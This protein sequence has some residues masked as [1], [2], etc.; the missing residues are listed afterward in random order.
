MNPKYYPIHERTPDY[1]YNDI[2]REIRNSDETFLM[3]HPHQT[4]GRYVNLDT[5]NLI[6]YFRNGFP[7]CTQRQIPFWKK[8]II[9]LLLFMKGVH[10]LEEMT[11]AGC[12][13]WADWVPQEKC[14]EFGLPAGDLGPRASYGPVLTAFP[15]WEINKDTGV[16]E[17][18]PF[19]QIENLISS[20]KDGPHM[21]GH[22]ITTWFPPLA[23]QHKKLKREVVVAPCHGTLVQATV[24]NGQK[25]AITMIQ[26]SGDVPVG[27]V[28]NI[29]QWAA[30]CIMVGH[31]CGYEP[32]K[33]IH[34]INDA[35]I[36]ST[37]IESVDMLLG[38]KPYVFPTLYLNKE[39]LN[40]TNI[41]DFKADH[42]ILEDYRSHPFMK[43][44]TTI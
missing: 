26:R 44:P 37:Q 20:L 6:Y 32:Y 31:V 27:V 33:F 43:I 24:I 41:L 22:V 1:Q 18:R 29:I 34:K 9:E 25:L 12:G 3:K 10:T 23:M 42:F 16:A 28:T 7:V 40:V 17:Y 30:F 8:S 15:H 38:R 5:A 19:N 11:A 4:N 36:Y 21:N 39:G 14:D 2:L 13:W 35:Q